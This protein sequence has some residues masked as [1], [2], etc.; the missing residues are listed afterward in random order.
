MGG[1]ALNLRGSLRETH[2]VD[3]AV[4]CDMHT[5][6]QSCM[7]H[8]RPWIRGNEG[9]CPS[10]ATVWRTGWGT[11]GAGGFD[12]A[13]SG[14]LEAPE[15]L[16]GTTETI[17]TQTATGPRSYVVIDLLRHFQGKLGAFFIRNGKKDYE[18]FFFMCNRFFQQ[19]G[20]FCGRL[21]LPQREH[22]MEQY[23]RE[24]QGSAMAARVKNM[25]LLLGL[26]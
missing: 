17:V 14:S 21:D 3:V 12:I 7:S 10:G 25:K 11:V 23:A 8:V 2:D 15:N 5:L 24:N 16:S 22:F 18:D 20:G 1:L 9:V 4:V 13:S 6:R 19:V 26:T